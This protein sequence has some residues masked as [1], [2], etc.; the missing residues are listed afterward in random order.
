M[1]DLPYNGPVY[2]L[3]CHRVM[4]EPGTVCGRCGA[5]QEETRAALVARMNA[6]ARRQPPWKRREPPVPLNAVEAVACPTCHVPVPAGA[7][8][9]GYCGHTMLT[10]LPEWTPDDVTA[11][12]HLCIALV[13][14]ALGLFIMLSSNQGAGVLLILA[15]LALAMNGFGH[16]PLGWTETF[17]LG[18]VLTLGIAALILII[19]SPFWAAN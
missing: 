11:Q 18:F 8:S 17:L 15:G 12:R 7:P 13:L 3:A 19:V 2:C 6:P 16:N 10:D 5:E 1:S 14:C 9:C 4:P